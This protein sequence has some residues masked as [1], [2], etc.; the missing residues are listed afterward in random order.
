[1]TMICPYC[2]CPAEWVDNAVIYG[3]RYG[4]SWMTWYC[5]PCDA[6]VGCHQNTMRPLGTMADAALRKTRM[7]THA[8]IDGIWR[9]KR[10][11]KKKRSEMYAKLS[12]AIGEEV[13]VGESDAARCAEIVRQARILYPEH[14]SSGQQ[15]QTTMSE[16]R[17]D[18]GAFWWATDKNTGA[19][20]RT[21]NGDKYMTGKVTINGQEFPA[22]LFYNKNKQ[23]PRSP[24][25]QIVFSD[26]Q[27]QQGAAPARQAPPE[28]EIKVE[29]IPF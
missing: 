7:E 19:E 22:T 12:D 28:E 27:Q 29:D 25:I 21:K 6:R 20:K 11:A 18:G 16:Q 3:K 9:G 5:R 2:D 8:A 15:P 14:F 4:K 10:K 13:H 23:N 1:M 24:D 17:K 26:R